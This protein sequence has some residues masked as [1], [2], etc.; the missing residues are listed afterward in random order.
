MTDSTLVRPAVA[1]D[2]AEVGEMAAELVRF[3]HALDPLRFLL[4]D[5][6]AQGYA[7]WFSS[8]LDVKET[9]ILVAERG[10]KKVGYAYARLEPRDWNALLDVH[11]ALH[12][13]YVIP[14]ARRSGAATALMDEVV[15]RLTALGAPRVVLSSA[16][17]NHGAHRLFERHGFRYTMVEMTRER[18]TE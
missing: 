13:I 8:Q 9:V 1:A 16:T 15:K 2:L 12:D 7:K 6:V 18:S 14:E 5:G 17:E 4:V 11:G 3:H 10:G